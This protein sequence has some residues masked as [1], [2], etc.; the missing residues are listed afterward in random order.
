MKVTAFSYVSLLKP[1]LIYLCSTILR[2][3]SFFFLVSVSPTSFTI[4]IFT[5][6]SVGHILH[7][8]QAQT[9][10]AAGV[11]QHKLGRHLIP[12]NHSRAWMTSQTLWERA[13]L[14]PLIREHVIAINL[15]PSPSPVSGNIWSEGIW[16][17]GLVCVLP[18]KDVCIYNTNV[19]ISSRTPTTKE[20]VSPDFTPQTF[21]HWL[22]N[23]TKLVHHFFQRKTQRCHVV[24]MTFDQK[25][26]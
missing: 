25:E 22:K 23:I 16:A 17:S 13:Q 19:W 12:V 8:R 18:M 7:C 21:K 11:H 9:R 4:L 26:S 1:R 2:F 15:L 6:R 20:W 3:S 24:S 10:G 14:N 5:G